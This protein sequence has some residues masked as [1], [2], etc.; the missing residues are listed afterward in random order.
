MRCNYCGMQ[1]DDNA[2]TCSNCGKPLQQTSNKG[3]MQHQP[4]VIPHRPTVLE[5]DARKVDLDLV[6]NTPASREP[7]QPTNCK[8]CNYPLQPGATVCPNCNTPVGGNAQQATIQPQPQRPHKPTVIGTLT[9]EHTSQQPEYQ[10]HQRYKD[11]GIS[12]NTNGPQIP[13][14]NNIQK[15]KNTPFKGTVNIYDNPMGMFQTEFTLTPIKRNNERHEFSTLNFEGDEVVLNR[16]NLEQNN[17][18]ITSQTQAIISC[19]DGKFY[20]TDKSEFK[21][22]FVQA[23]DKIEI[24]DGDIVLMGNRMFEFHA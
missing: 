16:A 13:Q 12:F 19:E 6:D 20:I 23:K 5:P 24:K 21:T 4:S 17:M 15:P 2:S 1:N 9:D 3:A 22:T 8:K 11:S 10:P 18:S 14:P 7:K